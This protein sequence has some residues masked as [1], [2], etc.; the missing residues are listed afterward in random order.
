MTPPHLTLKVGAVSGVTATA[1]FDDGSRADVTG[2]V[3]WSVTPPN[4]ARVD[5]LSVTDNLAR[6]TALAVGSAQLTARTGQIGSSPVPVFVQSNAAD[7]GVV[8]EVRAIWVTRFAYNSAAEVQAIIDR[9]AA[10]GFNVVY[11]QIRGNGDAYYRSSLVPWAKKLTGTLGKE[12]GWDPLQT[13]ID[14]ARLRG[15]EL[16]AYW[17]VYAGWTV[18][19]GCSSTTCTCRPQQGQADSCVLPEPSAD[20]GAEHLLR[21]H[22]E[23]MAVTSAGTSIDT[24]YY[25]FSPGHPQVKAHLLAAATELLANYDV[26]GLHLDR[27]RYPGSSYSYDP[28]SQAAYDA[29]PA[30]Q[31]P[32]YA[33]WQ[34]QQVTDF[35][36]QVYA[37]LKQRR[38]K[39]V[40][41]AS[42][43]GIYKPLPGCNT[44]QG[45]GNYY[46]DSI[47]W[48]KA[49]A[50]DAI[51]PMMY[52]DIG[53]GC[54]DW[55]KLLDGFMAGSNG[56]H[57]IAGMH[58]LDNGVPNP[59]RLRAR[60]DLA[61]QVGAA[62]TSIFASNYLDRPAAGFDGGTA[63]DWFR[64]DGG[65][66]VQ[67]AGTPRMPWRA[68]GG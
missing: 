48:M 53:T 47:G 52:W 45:Y 4:V 65:P 55:S 44:S 58:A 3:S 23:Y 28:G 37:V 10:A 8:A 40:L 49:G 59:L 17:N 11:F 43:W 29:L 24:E 63:W 30:T 66:Y 61:R 1:T 56:R 7:A 27:V 51:T 5:V 13:A 33:D 46:Q 19:A 41:S 16:H 62:G 18:P 57:V 20:G 67:D 26:D 15:V 21:A 2:T 6:L 50:I 35:V 22:P 36:T 54:T 31:R 32:T 64:S 68:D 25:W 12:P 38:P 60:I 14:R 42:V 34:R 39:A 9:A